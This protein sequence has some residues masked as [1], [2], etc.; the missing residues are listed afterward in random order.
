MAKTPGQKPQAAHKQQVT[1]STPHFSGSSASSGGSS[2]LQY[3]SID[4]WAKVYG[5]CVQFVH[6][7]RRLSSMT[8]FQCHFSFIPHTHERH[9]LLEI[10]VSRTRMFI[11]ITVVTSTVI[12]AMSK[13][14][15]F[16]FTKH[17]TGWIFAPFQ[18]TARKQK[19]HTST[20]YIYHT[21]YVCLWTGRWVGD[22][23]FRM[24]WTQK[25]P[26]T[27]SPTLFT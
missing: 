8:S 4:L 26:S 25:Q 10:R 19:S 18:R 13:E 11:T 3:A 14:G 23:I 5:P 22:L 6:Q 24:N 7:L 15:S 27:F 16:I 17:W 9:S 21:L 1:I 12:N 2:P 20:A